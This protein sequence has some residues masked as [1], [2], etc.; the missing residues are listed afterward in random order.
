[1]I[2]VQRRGRPARRGQVSEGAICP[3]SN[4]SNDKDH[5]DP[6]GSNKLG[7]SEA[8]IRP[9]EAP[10]GPFEAFAGLL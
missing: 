5:K 3:A 10:T 1:M 7:P 2:S 8:L 9:F 4:K 6:L